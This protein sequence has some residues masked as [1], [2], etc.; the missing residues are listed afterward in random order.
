MPDFNLHQSDASK[1]IE[2]ARN[3]RISLDLN[4]NPATGYR[5]S[6]PVFDER[7]LTLESEEF[8]PPAQGSIGGGGIRHFIFVAKAK[9]ETSIRVEYKRPWEKSERP[10]SI[11]EITILVK[12]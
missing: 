11:L 3:S 10:A 1:T 6:H 4:E 7:Y 5:W 2:V 8:T 12:A 9:G